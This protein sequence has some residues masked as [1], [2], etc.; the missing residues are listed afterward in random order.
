MLFSLS[1]H[2]PS[3]DT[4]F[5]LASGEGCLVI[6]GYAPYQSLHV[7]I[8]K[9][10]NTCSN[11]LV[12]Q[13]S[14]L[15]AASL[16]TLQWPFTKERS[17]VSECQRGVPCSS[18]ESCSSPD[19][20]VLTVFQ[21]LVYRGHHHLITQLAPRLAFWACWKGPPT[22]GLEISRLTSFG[23]L[24][25]Q[26]SR[27][28]LSSEALGNSILLPSEARRMFT[29]LLVWPCELLCVYQQEPCHRI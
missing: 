14:H 19:S 27:P 4:I 5:R 18:E 26:L 2:F 7:P 9:V 16:L 12:T 8:L 24:K 15:E 13:T 3:V 1:L 29:L 10:P 21:S 23:R 11:L 28:V 22:E 20:A 25:L 17:L 6:L